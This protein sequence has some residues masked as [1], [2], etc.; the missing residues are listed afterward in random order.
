MDTLTHEVIYSYLSSA[1]LFRRD[2]LR[3]HGRQIRIRVR[4]LLC[5]SLSLSPLGY[6]ADVRRSFV[7]TGTGPVRTFSHLCVVF[8]LVSCVLLLYHPH[9]VFVFV[10]SVRIA[11]R[12]AYNTTGLI[13]LSRT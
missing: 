13:V 9:R 12:N 7:L 2:G 5:A 11:Q 10:L 4:C 8:S 6:L 1:L 3:R